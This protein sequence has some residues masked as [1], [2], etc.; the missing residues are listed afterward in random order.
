MGAEQQGLKL[1][2]LLSTK[3][4]IVQVVHEQFVWHPALGYQGS[5]C[6]RR[7]GSTIDA[8][9]HAMPNPLISLNRF[10]NVGNTCYLNAVLQALLVVEPFVE[11]LRH[12][13]KELVARLQGDEP[14]PTL[15]LDDDGGVT[16]ETEE[17]E[18]KPD[19]KVLT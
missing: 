12:L 10:R 6:R 5:H 3:H 7:V 16:E 14:T 11:S 19:P 8:C 1:Q 9:K 4:A 15:V 13:G 2:H 17:T 18:D